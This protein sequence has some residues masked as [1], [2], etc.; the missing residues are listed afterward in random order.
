LGLCVWVGG[1]P[2]PVWAAGPPNVPA[3]FGDADRARLRPA[4]HRRRKGGGNTG[5][6]QVRKMVEVPSQRQE[7]K[8]AKTPHNGG[9]G[10]SITDQ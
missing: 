2:D 5:I 3:K 10:N 9:G 8:N 4:S 6:P 1:A 7:G